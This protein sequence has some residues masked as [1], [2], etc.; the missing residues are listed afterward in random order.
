MSTV[1]PGATTATAFL[2]VLNAVASEVPALASE[3]FLP[4]T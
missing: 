2:S 3:P 4:S 1:S